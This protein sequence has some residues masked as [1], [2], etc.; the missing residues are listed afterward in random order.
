V[1]IGFFAVL[2][3]AAV[4]VGND[5]VPLDHVATSGLPSRVMPVEA[6]AVMVLPATR[7]FVVL[8]RK[9]PT[10]FLGNHVVDDAVDPGRIGGGRDRART[11]HSP[12]RLPLRPLIWTPMRLSRFMVD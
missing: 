12:P 7:L 2:L 4:G 11:R 10:W 5:R 3:F 9:T 1:P 6:F 8:A